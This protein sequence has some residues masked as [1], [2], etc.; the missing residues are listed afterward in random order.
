MKKGR[1]KEKER[2]DG[3]LENEEKVKKEEENDISLKLDFR[4][5]IAIDRK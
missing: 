5:T 1:R 4:S 3:K 2:K